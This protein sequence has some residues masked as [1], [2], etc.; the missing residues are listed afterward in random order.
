MRMT[1]SGAYGRREPQA[2]VQTILPFPFLRFPLRAF[3]RTFT[4][5]RVVYTTRLLS[6]LLNL[7]LKPQYSNICARSHLDITAHFTMKLFIYLYL[8]VFYR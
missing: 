3:R 6:C 4:K 8:L 1:A 5:I 7:T 2:P